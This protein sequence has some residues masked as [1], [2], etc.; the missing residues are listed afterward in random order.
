MDLEENNQ[1]FGKIIRGGVIKKL[2][3]A[4]ELFR[5]SYRDRM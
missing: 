3:I 1:F 4:V 5:A 2:V